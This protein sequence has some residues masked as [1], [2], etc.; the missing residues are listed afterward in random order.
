MCPLKW[1][2]NSYSRICSDHFNEKFINRNG[3][4]V[5]LFTLMEHFNDSLK[6]PFFDATTKKFNP[7]TPKSKLLRN[8]P[9]IRCKEGRFRFFFE[10]FAFGQNWKSSFGM[11]LLIFLGDSGEYSGGRGKQHQQDVFFISSWICAGKV[12]HDGIN[13]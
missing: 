1:T 6:V 10:R 5:K 3:Q 12:I 11:K 2:P 8:L 13:I 4:V 7:S 9:C